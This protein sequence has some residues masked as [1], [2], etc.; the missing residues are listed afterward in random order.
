MLYWS[1]EIHSLLYHRTNYLHPTA[2]WQ[3]ALV[4]SKCRFY[5]AR[6]TSYLH[7][8]NVGRGEKFDPIISSI[9]RKHSHHQV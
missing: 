1:F 3:R 2:S 6:G 5:Y 9:I 4:F 7:S 8:L